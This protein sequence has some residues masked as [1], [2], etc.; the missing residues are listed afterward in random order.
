M[1]SSVT[2]TVVSDTYILQ[3]YIIIF[4]VLNPDFARLNGFKFSLP[5][6][7]KRQSGTFKVQSRLAVDMCIVSLFPTPAPRQ[8]L[9]L[10]FVSIMPSL[11]LRW[12][13]STQSRLWL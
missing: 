4:V 8:P 3:Y 5:L 12:T 13:C 2:I 11:H 6:S 1:V 7:C 10:S 9:F